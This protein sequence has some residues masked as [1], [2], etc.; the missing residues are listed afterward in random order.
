MLPCEPGSSELA[1][2]WHSLPQEESGCSAGLP[3]ALSTALLSRT[4]FSRQNSQSFFLLL[5]DFSSSTQ[6]P[7]EFTCQANKFVPI[8]CHHLPHRSTPGHKVLSRLG[9][10]ISGIFC[11]FVCG[12]FLFVFPEGFGAGHWFLFQFLDFG[13]IE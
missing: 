7:C 9:H 5:G 1:A 12:L 13:Y 4:A 2:A 11:L 10:W 8:S 3:A 6:S